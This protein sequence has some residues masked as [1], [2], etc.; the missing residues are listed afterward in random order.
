MGG[1]SFASRFIQAAP[2][3]SIAVPDTKLASAEAR[4]TIAFA[5]SCRL[6]RAAHRRARQ[7]RGP[8]RLGQAVEPI[9]YARARLGQDETRHDRVH[10]DARLGHHF[11]QRERQ[12][13]HAGLGRRIRQDLRPRCR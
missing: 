8:S 13:E 10:G 11:R 5:I 2:L 7:E 9:A 3:T 6:A 1:N 12:A 4:K